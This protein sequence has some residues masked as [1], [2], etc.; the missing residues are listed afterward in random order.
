[1]VQRVECAGVVVEAVLRRLAW[2]GRHTSPPLPHARGASC[3]TDLPSTP[4]QTGTPARSHAW[5]RR[6]FPPQQYHRQAGVLR[7]TVAALWRPSPRRGAR[8]RCPR[9]ARVQWHGDTERV[10]C[11]GMQVPFVSVRCMELGGLPVLLWAPPAAVAARAVPLVTLGWLMV[12][13]EAV[14]LS[15]RASTS[16]GDA[17]KYCGNTNCLRNA[18]CF[19]QLHVAFT[20]SACKA[21]V[22]HAKPR[23]ESNQFSRTPQTTLCKACAPS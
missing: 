18:P 14:V 16:T 22:R 15:T 8:Q 17:V 11:R 9:T 3:S 7:S 19:I 13:L 4:S 6:R 5:P 23:G 1:M 21:Y 12:P 10:A 20:C 2:R